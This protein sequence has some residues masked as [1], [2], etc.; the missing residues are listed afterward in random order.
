MEIWLKHKEEPVLVWQQEL[1]ADGISLGTSAI[2]VQQSITTVNQG[3]SLLGVCTQCDDVWRRD[4][5][6]KSWGYVLHGEKWYTNDTMDVQCQPQG[7]T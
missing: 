1:E 2:T 4:L 3:K 5:A 7:Q 6:N